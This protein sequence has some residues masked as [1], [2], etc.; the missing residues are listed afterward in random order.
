MFNASMHCHIFLILVCLSLLLA[1][2]SRVSVL[3]TSCDHKPP[4]TLRDRL[5]PHLCLQRRRFPVLHYYDVKR[6]AFALHGADP[7]FLLRTSSSPYCALKV[8][9]HGSLWQPPV[10]HSDERSPPQKSS[11]AHGCLNAF[12]FSDLEST[13]VG[14]HPMVSS[15]LRCAPMMRSKTRWCTVRSLE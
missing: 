10:A 11:C 12:K 1:I 5:D 6:P 2:S 3:L 8:S 13:V 9:E 4:P 14:S 7:L 15:L